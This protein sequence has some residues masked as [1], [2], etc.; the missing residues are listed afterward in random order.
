MPGGVQGIA[1]YHVDRDEL[2]V[3]FVTCHACIPGIA[4]SADIIG[5]SF[6]ILRRDS[7]PAPD[8]DTFTNFG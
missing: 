3:L 6:E 7:R 1:P 4:G 5:V 8:K 2:R